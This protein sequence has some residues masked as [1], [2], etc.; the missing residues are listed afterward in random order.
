MRKKT[1][2]KEPNKNHKTFL[3]EFAKSLNAVAYIPYREMAYVAP[4]LKA[5]IHAEEVKQDPSKLLTP[6][7]FPTLGSTEAPVGFTAPPLDFLKRLKESEEERKQREAAV[8]PD[9]ILGKSPE[10]LIAA[11]WAVLTVSSSAAAASWERQT[12]IAPLSEEL[13]GQPQ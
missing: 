11:G 9:G 12:K 10:A 3:F 4:S 2:R 5:R 8:D 7:N 13:I 6:D 1:N